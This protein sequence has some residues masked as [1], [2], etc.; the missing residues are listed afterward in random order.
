MTYSIMPVDVC[1][2]RWKITPSHRT[3]FAEPHTAN[4][5]DKC[6]MWSSG[7]GFTTDSILLECYILSLR[8]EFMTARR[9]L[10]PSWGPS[11][12]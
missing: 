9:I 4:C 11:S 2:E 10:I 7:T 8:K 3:P 1:P 12:R 6:E 5:S